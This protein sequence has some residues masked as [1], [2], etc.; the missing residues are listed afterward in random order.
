MTRIFTRLNPVADVVLDLSSRLSKSLRARVARVPLA[1]ALG[2]IAA[3]EYTALRDLPEQDKSVLDG[4]AVRS[5]D[6]AGA[7]QA[8]PAFLRVVGSSTPGSPFYGSLEPGTAVRVST[9]SILPR[10]ADT[11][12]PIE[13]VKNVGNSILV[14]K[15]FAPGY[16]VMKRGEDF[17][18]GDVIVERGKRIEWWHIGVLAAQGYD[19]VEIL[20]LPQVALFVVG[21]EVVEPGSELKPGMVYNSTGH[22]I[23]A[24]L[25]SRGFRVTY[26][27]LYSDDV[28][29][30]RAGLERAL[31]HGDIILATGGTSVGERDNTARVLREYVESEGGVFYHGFLL[32]PG[33]PLGVG[34][35]GGKLVASLSG[36]PVAAWAQVYA[37]IE[38]IVYKALGLPW[39]PDPL[40]WAR[41]SRRIAS[42]AGVLDVIRVRVCL[43]GVELVL[44]PLRVTGSGVLS[45]L[46]EGNAVLLVPP[47]S[48]GFDE[49][50]LAP[51]RL[52]HTEIPSC[53]SGGGAGG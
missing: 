25:T 15:P 1:N 11:V 3:R 6:V 18:A 37:V 29:D 9:G 44:Q 49:G 16:G 47:E 27:G 20:E 26:L 12:I 5:V 17:R 53:K 22:L 14:Y 8:E 34:V 21:D 4:Y 30:V 45:T 38:Q 51:V 43:E 52:L 7:S 39:P 24:Y 32:R 2:R 50:S 36:F 46:V 35:A 19:T 13:A 23:S 41:V 48:T 28:E 42:P 31:K 33:R 40:L 10:G